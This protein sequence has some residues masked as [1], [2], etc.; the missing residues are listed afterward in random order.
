MYPLTGATW[1][2]YAKNSKACPDIAAA[3]AEPCYPVQ[4]G[5]VCKTTRMPP[6]LIDLALWLPVLMLLR[7][8]GW[9]AFIGATRVAVMRTNGWSPSTIARNWLQ[10]SYVCITGHTSSF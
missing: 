8:M 1:I 3:S 5:S 7:T 4:K 10:Y 6:E 9:L 2:S